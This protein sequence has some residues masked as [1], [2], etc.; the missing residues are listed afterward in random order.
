MGMLCLMCCKTRRDTI[1]RER[2]RESWGNTYSRK[3]GEN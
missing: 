2:E 1:E 3:D